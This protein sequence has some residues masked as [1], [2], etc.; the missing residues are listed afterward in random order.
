VLIHC[1]GDQVDVSHIITTVY[2]EIKYIKTKD[3]FIITSVYAC[4]QYICLPTCSSTYA[5]S[6]IL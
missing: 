5:S 1:L 6:M 2:N 3:V 4:K